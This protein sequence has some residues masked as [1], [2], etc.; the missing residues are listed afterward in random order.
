MTSPSTSTTSGTPTRCTPFIPS[1][2]IPGGK[3][4]RSDRRSVFITA[5]NPIDSQP[6]RRE[7][8]Y[9]LDKSRTAPYKHTWRAHHNTVYWCNLKLAQRGIAILSNS[10]ACNYSFRHTTSDFC[11]IYKSPRVT[12]RNTCAELATRSDGCTFFRIEKNPMTV[13]MKFISTS[14]HQ[15]ASRERIGRTCI[16]SSWR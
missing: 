12:S 16:I 9:N 5:V 11:R 7:V 6:D 2:L 4:N 10:I 8:E 13:R 3:G 14:F 1:G 15:R